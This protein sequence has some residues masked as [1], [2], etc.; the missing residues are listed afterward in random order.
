MEAI[1][2]PTDPLTLE[3]LPSDI[4]KKMAL[5]LPYETIISL[6]T[7]S[8]RLNIIFSDV[9]FWRNYFRIQVPININ[10]PL[11]VNS[12]WYKQRIREYPEI[13]KLTDLLE[14]GKVRAKYIQE[15]NENWDIFERVENL[16]GL[17]CEN[18]QLISLPS[19]PNLQVLN[20]ENDQLT[21][22][23]SMPNLRVLCCRNNR[24]TSLPSYPNLQVLY[25][26]NNQLN[27][28]PSYPNLRELYC[29]NND[30]LFRRVS[31]L[32]TIDCWVVH[33]LDLLWNIG[34]IWNNLVPYLNIKYNI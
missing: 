11:G 20:C 31:G 18:N 15:F 2:P 14:Q 16:Q 34:K 22:L 26:Q 10:I 23:P 30:G 8:K 12:N 29:Y 28:L 32:T 19:M 25:C 1:T 17:N 7:I 3:T 33:F 6:C 5:N 4:Q 24:L 9:Y 21:S 13:K 27:S